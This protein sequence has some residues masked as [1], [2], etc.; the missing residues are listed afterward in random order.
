MSILCKRTFAAAAYDVRPYTSASMA[1]VGAVTTF[2][3]SERCVPAGCA[4]IVHSGVIRLLVLGGPLSS[5][6]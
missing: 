2:R 6:Y 1:A 3:L 5:V 4:V